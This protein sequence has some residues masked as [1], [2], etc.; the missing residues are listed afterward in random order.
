M[1]RGLVSA[2][3]TSVTNQFRGTFIHQ[4]Y[5]YYLQ[6]Q[7]PKKWFGTER[8]EFTIPCGKFDFEVWKGG[9]YTS[10][11]TWPSE[12]DYPEPIVV[13][14]FCDILTS[15]STFYNIG[16]GFGY[17]HRVASVAGVPDDSIYCFEADSE[18]AS[19][20][21][22]NLPSESQK[23]RAFV[24]DKV[25]NQDNQISIDY[26][27]DDT[28]YPT[29]IKIDIQGSE[30]SAVR[31]MRDTLEKYAPVLYVEL[32]PKLITDGSVDDMFSLLR[33]IGYSIE[34]V[35]H[36]SRGASWSTPEKS[37]FTDKSENGVDYFMRATPA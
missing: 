23:V 10:P 28:N 16:A 36:R 18:T 3:P 26:F 13:D 22:K 12:A 6:L 30:L 20:L 9:N 35:N 11:D 32:H 34:T 33:S 2:L 1:I 19:L 4:Y 17:Y 24:S 14:E 27:V 31:G 15:N 25:N 37:D 21:D 29:V 5:R 8:A 7:L